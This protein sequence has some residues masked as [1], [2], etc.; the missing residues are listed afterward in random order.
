[1]VFLGHDGAGRPAA[2]SV[3]HAGAAADAAARDRLSAA[4][5]DLAREAPQDV[6]A[7]APADPVPWVATTYLGED[8]SRA[9]ALLDAAALS[10]AAGLTAV[11]GGSLAGHASRGAGPEFAPHWSGTP[12]AT[13]VV[14]PAPSQ[15][16]SSVVPPANNRR[17]LAI[18][19]VCV[20]V[21]LAVVVG[22]ALLAS[23]VLEDDSDTTA[24]SE[25]TP[26][27]PTRIPT[28][29]EPTRT[30]EPRSTPQPEP[31]FSEPPAQWHTEEPL[32]RSTSQDGPP[33]L[34]AGPTFGANEPTYLMDLEGFPFDF[35]VP[36][37][38]GC[39]RSDKGGPGAA[40]WVCID[41]GYIFGSKKGDPPGG[42]V[43][44][45]TCPA[46]CGGDEW[47]RVRETVGVQG[48]WRRVD[49]TTM[50]AEW[51]LSDR[52]GRVGVAMSHVFS[53]EGDGPV[54][55]HVG[56]RLTGAP[57][58]LPSMQKIINEIRAKTP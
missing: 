18:L 28:P 44:V 13:Q 57:D 40:R 38:W 35:R 9:V 25:P 12:A 8:L 33:G 16:T 42:I 37:T 45:R 56:V 39:M 36:R 30:P 52:S 27:E 48:D 20:A 19:A 26:S 2:I 3:L 4:L 58:E 55:T 14:P 51:Q 7:A 32:P 34:V 24:A 15:L 1:M 29:S 21:A 54:D 17:S 50:Y 41:E 43:E 6:L 47:A 31:S 46:P 10:R 23:V 5:D 53:A 22:G 49:E 11:E